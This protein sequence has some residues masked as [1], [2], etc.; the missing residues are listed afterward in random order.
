MLPAPVKVTLA[1][2]DI[3]SVPPMV[4]LLLFPEPMA[5]EPDRSTLPTVLLPPVPSRA[6][7]PSTPLPKSVRGSLEM[8]RLPATSS[9][10]PKPTVV[11]ALA[12]PRAFAFETTS[13]PAVIKVGP[14]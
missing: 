11:P 8:S 5:A 4:K 12:A 7:T 6:P 2:G 14:T 10:A 13:M 9:V 1:S 3:D